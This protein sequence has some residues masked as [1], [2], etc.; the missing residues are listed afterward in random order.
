MTRK[1]RY[2][3]SAAVL[4]ACVCVAIAFALPSSSI[5][6]EN[7]DQIEQGMTLAQVERILGGKGDAFVGEGQRFWKHADGTVI[8]VRLNEG[9]VLDQRFFPSTESIPDKLHRWMSLP[10]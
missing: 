2:L 9:K 8:I 5:T 3:I 7:F 4:A 10:K 1:R 6:K